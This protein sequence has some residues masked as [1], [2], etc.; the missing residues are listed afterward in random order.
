MHVLITGC[1]KGIG[2]ALTE[3]FLKQGHEVYATVR[4]LSRS[5]DLIAIKKTFLQL[6]VIEMDVCS[7]ASVDTAVEK[8]SK[9]LN[10]LDILVNNAAIFPEEGDESFTD[11]NVEFF[12][13]AVNTNVTGVARVTQATLPLIRKGEE[14]RIVNISSGAGSISAKTEAKHYCYGASK[15]A[16]NMFSKTLSLELAPEGIIVAAVSP[17]WV[18]TEMGGPNA[19]ITTQESAQDLYQTTMNLTMG[20]TGEFLGRDGDREAYQW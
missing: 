1:N 9:A 7:R 11:L 18:Q 15:A 17:G 19:K 4:D 20:D 16:L 5:A 14:S 6:S 8:L 13:E 3:E 2:L 12:T 10:G